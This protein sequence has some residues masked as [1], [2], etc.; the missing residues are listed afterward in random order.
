LCFEKRASNSK[1]REELKEMG[2]IGKKNFK[3]GK[4]MKKCWEI[5]EIY[6][7]CEICKKWKNFK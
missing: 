3:I 5:G 1:F 4:N 2:K 6:G 7:K